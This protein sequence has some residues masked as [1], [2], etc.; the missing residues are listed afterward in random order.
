[1]SSNRIPGA[2]ETEVL[3]IGGGIA[4]ASTA[5]HLAVLGYT[6][7]LVERGNIASE[8]SGVNA[9]G[10]G[11]V[12][13]GNQPDLQAYLTMGSLEVF[14]SLQSDLGYDIEFRLTGGLQAIQTPG[15][16]DFMRDRVS[17]LRSIARQARALSRTRRGRSPC[18]PPWLL[19]ATRSV[20]GPRCPPAIG[21]GAF[22]P[23]GALS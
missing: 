6:V 20:E 11:G 9:G 8:A 13:W 4:G 21:R 22:S 2:V 19:A 3:V 23:S 16:Y 14:K 10:L 12:G 17:S 18:A 7:A 15:Q 5:Y 1:M